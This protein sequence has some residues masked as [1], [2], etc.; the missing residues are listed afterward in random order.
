M[1]FKYEI[2]DNFTLQHKKIIREGQIQ[3]MRFIS[4]YC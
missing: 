1:L 4:L 2:A 3:Q